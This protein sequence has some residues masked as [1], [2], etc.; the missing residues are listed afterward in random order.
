ML[1]SPLLGPLVKL[2]HNYLVSPYVLHPF[3]LMETF[4]HFTC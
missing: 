3:V 2:T 4:A 1:C